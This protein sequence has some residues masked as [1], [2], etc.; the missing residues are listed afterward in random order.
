MEIKKAP[1]AAARGAFFANG[2]KCEFKGRRKPP[3]KLSALVYNFEDI[4]KGI[5]T[6]K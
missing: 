1:P 6:Y 2:E 4:K 5:Q 3:L